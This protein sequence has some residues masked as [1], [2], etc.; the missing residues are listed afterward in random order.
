MRVGEPECLVDE[1]AAE[2]LPR[3]S[4]GKRKGLAAAAATNPGH[5]C[6]QGAGFEPATL[7]M[8][9]LR[10]NAP[11]NNAL[12]RVR[13]AQSVVQSLRGHRAMHHC[14]CRHGAFSG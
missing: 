14:A 12:T 6:L 8:S 11:A 7:G 5:S 1:A 2:A 3:R 4:L 9:A 10:T 13:V